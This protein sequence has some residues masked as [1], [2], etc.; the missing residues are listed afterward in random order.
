MYNKDIFKYKKGY[1]KQFIIGQDW[2][3]MGFKLKKK[4][5]I[6][7]ILKGLKGEITRQEFNLMSSILK[8]KS[9]IVIDG[10]AWKSYFKLF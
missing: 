10:G 6:K 2:D 3:C 8:N 7:E 4:Q 9:R 1:K 5:N